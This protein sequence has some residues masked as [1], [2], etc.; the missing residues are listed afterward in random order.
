[1]QLK[2]KTFSILSRSSLLRNFEKNKFCWDSIAEKMKDRIALSYNST[3]WGDG[4]EESNF[5]G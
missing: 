5:P 1:M 2:V 4:K 3:V